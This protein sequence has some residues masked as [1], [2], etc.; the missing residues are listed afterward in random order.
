VDH[1]NYQQGATKAVDKEV[2]SISEF[3]HNANKSEID[4]Q[5]EQFDFSYMLD[6]YINQRGE[7]H[8]N[9]ETLFNRNAF[10]C[11]YG[12]VKNKLMYINLIFD[13]YEIYNQKLKVELSKNSSFKDAKVLCDQ[14][15]NEASLTV[16]KIATDT[17]NGTN[18]QNLI[19]W[20]EKV[21][22]KLKNNQ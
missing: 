8:F 9:T 15:F 18:F 7:K 2:F 22:Q 10:F 19:R 21:K 12:R 13:V 11:T 5:G 16:K 3:K 4:K 17:N 20:S 1:K 14:K 6:M